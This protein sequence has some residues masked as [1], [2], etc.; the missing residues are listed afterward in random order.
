MFAETS[1]VMSF[2]VNALV[3]S[4]IVLKFSKVYSEVK[5]LV[6]GQTYG[7]SKIGTIVFVLIESAMVSFLI[8][9]ARLVVSM[10]WTDAAMEAAQCISVIHEMF[11]VIIPALIPA[12]LNL[13]PEK[14]SQG[15]DDIDVVDH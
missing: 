3:T 13:I 5:P 1:I 15:E 12:I 14:G 10:V 8:Q 9:L 11:N 7:G 2:T 4:L 6:Y